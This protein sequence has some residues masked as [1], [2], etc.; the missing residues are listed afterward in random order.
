M[1]GFVFTGC[2]VVR[3]EWVDVNGHMNIAHYT[4]VFDRAMSRLLAKMGIDRA[5]ITAGETTMVA[6]RIHMVYRKEMLEGESFEVWSGI[7]SLNQNSMTITQ[8]IKSGFGIRATCDILAV[9]FCP[10]TRRAVCI[11]DGVHGRAKT[12]QVPGILDF[13]SNAEP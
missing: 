2:D 11:P 9:A 7:A 1:K 3:P 6:S 10:V 12:C 13:F 4:D 8:R 5:S